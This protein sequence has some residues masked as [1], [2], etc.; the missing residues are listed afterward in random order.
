VSVV[1]GA[2]AV[3]VQAITVLWIAREVVT[4]GSRVIVTVVIGAR[5]GPIGTARGHAILIGIK[6]IIYR[7]IAVFIQAVT[8]LGRSRIDARCRVIAVSFEFTVGPTI[9]TTV[10]HGSAVGITVSIDIWTEIRRSG[11]PFIRVSVA[12]VVNFVA[13]LSGATMDRRVIIITVICPE[14]AGA[15]GRLQVAIGVSIK[16]LICET[17]AVV[18]QSVA[19]LQCVRKDRRIGV[20]TVPITGSEAIPV[21]VRA[22][23]AGATCEELND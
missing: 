20:I 17:A 23:T 18:I 6:P 13:D 3:I 9:S 15:T 19:D 10:R 2:V 16:A 11:R 22:I 4:P 14:D 7:A 12:V 8:D 5:R 1:H 21:I